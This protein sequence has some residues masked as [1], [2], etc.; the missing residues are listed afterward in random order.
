MKEKRKEKLNE[1]EAA[2]K[3]ASST[4]NIKPIRNVQGDWLI[5]VKKK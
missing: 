3:M 2:N 4:L 5:T 1:K